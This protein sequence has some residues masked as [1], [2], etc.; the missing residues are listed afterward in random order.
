MYAELA[1]FAL[2][3]AAPHD[4]QQL[5]SALRALP[6]D[7]VRRRLLG[8][9]S[10]QNRSMV[11]DGAFERGLAGDAAARAELR[12]AL[13]PNR[14]ARLG[15]D[16]LL[17]T[18]SEAVQ[19]EFADIVEEWALRVFPAFAPAALVVIGRDAAAKRRLLETSPARAVLRTATNGVDFEP[20]VGVTEIVI[21][22]AVALR[23]FLAPVEFRTTE[24]FLCSVGD[25][26]FDDDPAAPPRR[27]VK[28]AAALGD[29]LRLRILHALADGE[30]TASEIADRL[31]VERTSLH[32]HLGILRSAGLV[33]IRDDGVRGWRF[34]R[35]ADG[36][37]D[38]GAALTDYLGSAGD[39]G[40]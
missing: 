6:P 3:T 5:A 10:A 7:A 9:E 13:G 28:L 29:E 33:T 38:V 31:G 24:I 19:A 37:E 34:T 26:A 14:P 16:R 25:E 39:R 2:E 40:T 8:A 22:P 30:L 27:L 17:T 12:V 32:H 23:P 36:V 15:V 21:V 11:S 18:S 35:R 20:P 1:S 4:P